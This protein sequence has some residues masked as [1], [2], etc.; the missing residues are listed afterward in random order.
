M[1]NQMNK[2]LK[3]SQHKQQVTEDFCFIFSDMQDFVHQLMQER[4]MMKFRTIWKFNY[5]AFIIAETRMTSHLAKNIGRKYKIYPISMWLKCSRAGSC[6]F[7]ECPSLQCTI[8]TPSEK[9]IT[10]I[11]KWWLKD[12]QTINSWR[13]LKTKEKQIQL[14]NHIRENVPQTN[15]PHGRTWF[16]YLQIQFR[17]ETKSVKHRANRGGRLK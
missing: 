7:T 4:K 1:K 8:S 16:N 9:V 12:S 6:L 17:E 13:M 11:S 14:R 3:L 15:Y 5:I 2:V 10:A